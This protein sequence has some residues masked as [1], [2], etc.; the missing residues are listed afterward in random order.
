MAMNHTFVE[1]KTAY[2]QLQ[3]KLKTLTG[4]TPREQ[5]IRSAAEK[6]EGMYAGLEDTWDDYAA[7]IF[8]TRAKA[9]LN[10]AE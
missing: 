8:L 4:N 1:V 5:I 9:L 7:E 10:G 2:M 6:L 3:E